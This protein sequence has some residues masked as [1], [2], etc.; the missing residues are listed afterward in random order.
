MK[1]KEIARTYFDCWKRRD[2]GG[3]RV[4]L[5]D[6]VTFSGPMGN[7]TGADDYVKQLAGFAQQLDDITVEKMLADDHDVLTWFKLHPKGG[8]PMPVVNW[9]HVENGRVR[10]ARVTFDPR[11]LL[12]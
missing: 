5:A 9:S 12:N 8:D 1:P 6:E 7:A 10:Q 11:P 4:I 2:F 3:L